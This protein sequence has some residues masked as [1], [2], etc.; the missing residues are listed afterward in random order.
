[1]KEGSGAGS[2]AGS[3]SWSGSIPLTNGSGSGSRRPKNM[4]IRWIRIRVRIRNTG[5]KIVCWSDCLFPGNGV[6]DGQ[7]CCLPTV[8]QRVSRETL[9]QE[10][11]SLTFSYSCTVYYV[12]YLPQHKQL[13][14]VVFRIHI[15]VHQLSGNLISHFLLSSV[16]DPWHFGMD[17]DPRIPTSD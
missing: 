14:S 3:G 6:E 16:A 2:R 4:W 12:R 10:I 5:T 11:S 9:H 1:M 7:R 13:F 17:P 8:H 15:P